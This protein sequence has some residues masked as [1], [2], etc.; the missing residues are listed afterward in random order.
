MTDIVET[1]VAAP[2]DVVDIAALEIEAFDPDPWSTVLVEQAL[3]SPTTAVL[4]VRRDAELAGFAVVS[5]VGEDADLQRIA[6]A[7]RWRQQGLATRLL[8]E[9]RAHAV[10]TGGR[11]IL[12]EVREDNAVARAFYARHGFAELGRRD[13]YYRDGT[14]ALVLSTPV[15]MEV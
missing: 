13:R 12:L 15:T 10:R 7:A 5:V 14:A 2:D 6:V 11:R 4:V 1:G 8:A 3:A 9:V